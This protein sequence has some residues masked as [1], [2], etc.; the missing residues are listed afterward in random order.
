MATTSWQGD[1]A[2]VAQVDT[3][4]VTLFDA[5]TTYTLTINGKDVS[6]AGT[7]DAA[8]TATALA[9]A[10][11]AS[12][13][14]EVAEITAS[15]ATD[16]V[17]LTGDTAGKPF[18]VTSSVSGGTGT[19][20]AVT[21]DTAATGPNH[22][23]N[24]DNWSG[25]AVPVNADDVVIEQGSDILYGLGQSAVTLTSL[26]V[27]RSF[28][29]RIG[30]PEIAN[31]DQATGNRYA[32]YR[33][34]YLAIGA[35]TILIGEGPGTGSGRIKIDTGSVAHTMNLY[36]TG[37]PL[38]VGLPS[39]LLKGSNAANVLNVTRGSIGVAVLAGET[40]Q[41]AT[42]RVGYE[43]QVET[44]AQ[45]RLGGGVTL[46]AV[47]TSGGQVEING[48][49]TTMVVGAGTIDVRAGAHASI[50]LDGGTLVYRGTGTITALI[51]GPLA[52]ADF[53]KDLRDRTVTNC[54]VHRG[55]A[56]HDPNRT[57]TFTNGVEVV[58]SD[59]SDVTLRMGKHIN[60]AVTAG[61]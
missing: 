43:T 15:S 55:A 50:T 45:V 42:L 56:L 51:V 25:D 24:A 32:E 52:V 28:S 6:V 3:V 16:T 53:A 22:W 48:A 30:L 47:E 1:A 17:T 44:D 36:G 38:E 54:E 12:I 9:A 34:T 33:A 23:D 29:G 39:V 8:G 31:A 14:P 40:A 5:A 37:S 18:V 60:L 11:N 57:V 41:L 4:Q 19:I 35:T 26:T 27:K 10:W 20:G 7:T 61:A 46:A 49:T 21:S 2:A 59:V 13:E 58:R